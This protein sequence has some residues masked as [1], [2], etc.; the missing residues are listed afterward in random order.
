MRIAKAIADS[1]QASRRD[2]ERMILAGRVSVNGQV[3]ASPA[4]DVSPTDRVEVD[5]NPLPPPEP[6]RLFKYYKPAGLTTTHHDEH[7]RRTVFDDIGGG[8]GRLL[9]IGRLDLN[10]E[11][12]LLLTNSG[13]FQR[14]M[15]MGDFER[16]YRVRVR[17]IPAAAALASLANGAEIDGVRYKGVK[18]RLEREQSTN[19]WLRVGLSEGKN[20][21]IRRIFESLGHEVSR[22]VRISYAGIGLDGLGPGEITEIAVP[23]KIMKAFGARASRKSVRG[24]DPGAK[25]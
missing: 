5:G 6:L 13:E 7:N 2:A 15:E 12:L 14:F 3:I 25:K 18:A 1:G 19:A 4:L 17:G 11:G 23:K 20:R 22:L 10:S 24:G 9:S 21:E 8:Y 16:V